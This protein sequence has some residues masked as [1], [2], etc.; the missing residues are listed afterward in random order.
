MKQYSGE[1]PFSLTL[2]VFLSSL[3]LSITFT[4]TFSGEEKV[5]AK[6]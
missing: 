5:S 1:T 2:V 4:A 6:P 3:P